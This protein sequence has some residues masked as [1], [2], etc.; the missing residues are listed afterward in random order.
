MAF[1]E[2]D[3]IAPGEYGMGIG[4]DSQYCQK[5]YLDCLAEAGTDEVAKTECNRLMGEC[6]AASTEDGGEFYMNDWAHAAFLHF[7]KTDAEGKEHTFGDYEV[8]KYIDLFDQEDDDYAL[9]EI[10]EVPTL[11]G[12][13][14]TIGV[15][16]IQHKGEAG[17]IARVK[18]FEMASADPTDYVRKTGD[19]MTGDL[20]LLADT[21]DESYA[22]YP[23]IIFRY[24]NS[25]GVEYKTE[26]YQTSSFLRCTRHF[27][28][29]G[30]L[31]ANGNL[32]Y[33]GETRV[34]MSSAGGY[35][36]KGTSASKR[37]LE[38]DADGKVTKIQASN[39]YGERGQALTVGPNETLQ[40]ATPA[41]GQP[42]PGPFTWKFEKR[43]SGTASPGYVWW[44]D[45]FVYL[46]STTAEGAKLAVASA[47]STGA[48]IFSSY[49]L[50]SG[51]T[52]SAM[53]LKFWMLNSSGAWELKA[54]AVPYKYRF[55][56]G[57]WVQ[58]EFAYKQGSLPEV[59]ESLWCIT[60]PDL[61]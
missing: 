54:W 34:G 27:E 43:T 3:S 48:T 33:N 49:F 17:G 25:E 52:N 42:K 59:N 20:N 11:Q 47:L 18:V 16:P 5:K 2:G 53:N 37:S 61:I 28:S 58:L 40:W 15:S 6:E 36:G 24:P 44:K 45:S 13:I 8:G 35:L 21:Y 14:Y 56:Y 1:V 29:R 19:T 10:T 46:S 4:V 55:G 39:G 7:H 57:G 23:R 31:S 38:W 12:D 26:L 60:L 32:Q 50:G 51:I 30:T 41:A 9:F 22:S